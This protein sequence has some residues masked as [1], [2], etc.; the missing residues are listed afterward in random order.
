LLRI[1]PKPESLLESKPKPESE[2]KLIPQLKAEQKIKL[3]LKPRPEPELELEPGVLE[4][5]RELEKQTESKQNQ[6]LESDRD[7]EIDYMETCTEFCRYLESS[8]SEIDSIT[9]IK[10]N[11]DAKQLKAYSNKRRR[12]RIKKK[13]FINRKYGDRMLY[14]RT[15]FCQHLE[16]KNKRSYLQNDNIQ[17]LNMA[18]RSLLKSQH[19]V[20]VTP[21]CTL[22][23]NH[24][25]QSSTNNQ[26][27]LCNQGYQEKY[28]FQE[29]LMNEQNVDITQLLKDDD[30]PKTTTDTEEELSF[31]HDQI[32]VSEKFSECIIKESSTMSYFSDNNITQRAKT[33]EGMEA[34]RKNTLSDHCYH[35]NEPRIE[36]QSDLSESGK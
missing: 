2:R 27:Q 18:N 6:E 11:L 28:N 21:L 32:N 14:R 4:W 20:N 7:S 22:G 31:L 10:M 35:L 12:R 23:A 24:F 33:G 16:N 29:M 17:M 36:E 5:K 19:N 30:L 9:K 3:E 1:Q 25:H 13:I 15:Q 8:D 26:K 34:I